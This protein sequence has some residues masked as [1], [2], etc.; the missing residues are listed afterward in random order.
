MDF[1]ILITDS[2][3][4]VILELEGIL[5]AKGYKVCIARSGEEACKIIKNEVIHLVIMEVHLSDM[6]GF[7][8]CKSLRVEGFN[9]PII[10]LTNKDSEFYAVIGFEM[11]AQ[12]YIRK[13]LK[14]NEVIARVELQLKNQLTKIVNKKI[15]VKDLEIDLERRIVT[16]N[17]KVK[18]LTSKELQIL[19]KLAQNPQK[20]FSREELLSEIWGYGFAANTRTL[21]IHIGYLRKKIEDEPHRPKLFRTV[22]GI[23]YYLEV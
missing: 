20:V 22:R 18:E 17:G 1:K 12:D 2:D 15:K 16:Y 5:K 4:E 7:A 3:A 11:G 23:G 10:F 6:E 8:L 21:D 14:I 19:S 13:P 9:S